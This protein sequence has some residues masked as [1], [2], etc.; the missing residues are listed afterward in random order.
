M[1]AAWAI[2]KLRSEEHLSCVAR[3]SQDTEGQSLLRML[4]PLETSSSKEVGSKH[5]FLFRVQ[6]R[7]LPSWTPASS[8]PEKGESY[9]FSRVWLLST[10][11]IVA[12][13]APLSMGYSRQE[14]WSG[15]P[16]PSPGDPPYPGIKLGS[17]ALQAD[18]LLS[19]PPTR[20]EE[21][22]TPAGHRASPSQDTKETPLHFSF[23]IFL[24]R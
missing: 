21:L 6:W 22:R 11:W 3:L 7:T 17:P 20:H 15:L 18:S 12:H 2:S 14:Y 8:L 16:F 23:L 5:P 19:E 10:P 24:N 1:K 4:L 13:Q 9:S